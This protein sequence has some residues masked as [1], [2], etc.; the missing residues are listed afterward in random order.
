M[1]LNWIWVMPTK[2]SARKAIRV[3]VFVCG[4]LTFVNAIL[5]SLLKS[6]SWRDYDSS[7]RGVALENAVFYAIVSWRLQKNS[8]IFAV[9]GLLVTLYFYSDKFASFPG[10][11]LPGLVVLLLVNTVRATFLSHKYEK[12]EKESKISIPA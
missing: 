12:A 6:S 11:I 1:S 5:A 3:G 7:L 2:E 9:L 10:A 8:R 4:V